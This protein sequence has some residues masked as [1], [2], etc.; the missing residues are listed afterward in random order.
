LGLFGAR[1]F[2]FP[3]RSPGRADRQFDGPVVRD[4]GP[5]LRDDERGVVTFL[6]RVLHDQGVAVIRDRIIPLLVGMV[7]DLVLVALV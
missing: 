4:L 7:L 5:A 3:R 2:D 1:T 6:E